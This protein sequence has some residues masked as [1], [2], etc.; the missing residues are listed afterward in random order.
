M[1]FTLTEEHIKAFLEPAGRGDW[2]PFIAAIDPNVKWVIVDPVAD[3]STSAGTYVC[4][5]GLDCEI[6]SIS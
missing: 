3:S 6:I 5:F 4:F 2:A 1:S